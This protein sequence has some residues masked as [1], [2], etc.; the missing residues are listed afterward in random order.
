MSRERLVHSHDF[1]SHLS[2]SCKFFHRHIFLKHCTIF[3]LKNVSQY[4][5]FFSLSILTQIHV[6][7]V[8]LSNWCLQYIGELCVQDVV[9][10]AQRPRHAIQ[11]RVSPYIIHPPQHLAP[12]FFRRFMRWGEAYLISLK[13]GLTANRERKV[14][15]GG[16]K[17][18]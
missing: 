1:F 14:E 7:L 10:L 2:L 9:T 5:F 13:G 4:L 3:I 18:K 12:C 6:T 15:S 17:R 16:K 8:V 11:L